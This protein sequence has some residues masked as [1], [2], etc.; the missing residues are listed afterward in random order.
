MKHIS[1]KIYPEQRNKKYNPLIQETENSAYTVGRQ[2][3]RYDSVPIFSHYFI[4]DKTFFIT[5]LWGYNL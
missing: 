4:V 1:K 5:W 2:Q 3:S